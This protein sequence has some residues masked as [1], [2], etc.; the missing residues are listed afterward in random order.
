[1]NSTGAADSGAQGGLLGGT[2]LSFLHIPLSDASDTAL[3]AM[4]GATVSFFVSFL[5]KRIMEE[6]RDD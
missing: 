4:V 6:E 1:M 3:L 5:L 2:F